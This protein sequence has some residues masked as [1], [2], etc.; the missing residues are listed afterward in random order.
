[1][2]RNGHDHPGCADHSV[3]YAVAGFHQGVDDLMVHG[4]VRLSQ[5]GVILGRIE[6][7]PGGPV[8]L[9]A[10]FLEGL[11]DLGGD[12]GEGVIQLAVGADPV[13]VIQGGEQGGQDV[14]DAVLTEAVLL[15]LGPVAE[16]DEIGPFPLEGFQIVG[17]LFLGLAKGGQT[18]IPV[19]FLVDGGFGLSRGIRFGRGLLVLAL[20]EASAE[21]SLEAGPSLV[22]G[23]EARSESEPWAESEAGCGPVFP[24]IL[25]TSSMPAR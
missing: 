1:M 16:V 20:A 25:S 8:F 17:R 19:Q 11:V 15:F 4:G 9:H 24:A 13:D 14:D 6:I 18:P 5:N 2:G 7:L 21:P 12:R 22:A 23:T 10:E 3:A